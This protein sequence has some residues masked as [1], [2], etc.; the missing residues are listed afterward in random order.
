[1]I[2]AFGAHCHKQTQSM[3]KTDFRRAMAVVTIRMGG[4]DVRQLARGKPRPM[5]GFWPFLGHYVRTLP[6]PCIC[7][8]EFRHTLC[9]FQ[10]QP[11]IVL[12]QGARG[13]TLVRDPGV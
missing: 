8:P 6:A 7:L 2:R 12:S 13:L 3:C 5:Q 1:M 10:D 9:L 11:R 4:E